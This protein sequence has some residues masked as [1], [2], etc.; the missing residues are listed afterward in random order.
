MKKY[1]ICILQKHH[2]NVTN[3]QCVFNLQCDFLHKS[4]NL[5]TLM[6]FYMFK[7]NLKILGLIFNEFFRFIVKFNDFS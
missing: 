6:N 5:C 4:V 1:K 7:F 2:W 3:T